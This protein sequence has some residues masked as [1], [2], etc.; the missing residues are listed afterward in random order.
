MEQTT[1]QPQTAKHSKEQ[2]L[3]LLTEY[4]KSNGLTIKEFCRQNGVSEGSFYS[5]RSRFQ[6]K[7]QT[8]DKPGG[9]IA[10]GA[11]VPKEPI[12]TLF[13]E[14]KGIKIYQA[15]SAAYLKALAS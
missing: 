12:T 2:I 7:A 6:N 10:I 8:K 11:P 5:F 13:A 9:F 4:K 15:V 3:E 1:T 14:V